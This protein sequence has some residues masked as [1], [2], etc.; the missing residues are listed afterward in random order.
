MEIL[1]FRSQTVIQPSAS[2]QYGSFR[3]EFPYC[4][5]LG[6]EE[7]YRPCIH[8]NPIIGAFFTI[9]PEKCCNKLKKIYEQ[10]LTKQI[11]EMIFW[12]CVNNKFMKICYYSGFY[13]SL[14]DERGPNGDNFTTT[15][16]FK[17]IAM[18]SIIL[19][20]IRWYFIQYEIFHHYFLEI[21]CCC[22]I[23][24]IWPPFIVQGAVKT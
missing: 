17:K 7:C 24:A 12:K 14:N 23:V 16:N 2:G 15:Y 19:D 21:I 22:K 20:R 13:S 5:R 3:S 9:D 4:S 1:T 6:R 11:H 10:N 18:K 8:P